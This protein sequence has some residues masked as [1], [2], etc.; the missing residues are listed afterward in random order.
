MFLLKFSWKNLTRHKRRTVITAISLAVGLM[1]FI[2]MD[3]ML[4][5]A[6][7]I[8]NRN[9][10][11]AETGHGKILTNLAFEDM[12]FSPLSN[13]I[14][15]PDSIIKLV[16][17]NGAKASKRVVINGEIIYSNEYFPKEGSTQVL[18]TAVDLDSDNNVF[19]VM[20]EKNLVDGRFMENGSD[21]VV[22]G[23]WLAED[24]GAKVG[25]VFTLSLRTA[26]EGD[27]PGF[28]Q[29]ID[30]EIVGIVNVE[31]PNVNRRVVYFPLDMA[32]FYLDLN[33]SVTEVAV[34]LPLNETID[35]FNKKIEST[36]PE[37]YGFF[38]WREIG[39][40]YLALTEAKSGG[41]SI[42]MMLV[43]FIA[44]VGITN[45]IL[46]TINER[47]RELGMMRALGMSDKSIKLAFMI[48]AAGIGLIGAISGV[49]LGCLANIPMVNIGIDFSS[50]MRHT[51]IGY[52]IS[53]VMYGV[54]NFSAIFKAFIGGIII[55]VIVA[56]FPTRSATKKSI[57]DCIHGR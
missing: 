7:E 5:G 47:Q 6:F 3:S 56:Y 55:P 36:L 23:S 46:M 14:E 50:Y 1:M 42:M 30:V 20:H 54:W 41:S 24:I 13:R 37:G 27:D 40:D 12:K 34:K 44:I 18:F 28:Y 15:N 45:T 22:I 11:D 57:P 48:E 51:D 25:S 26:S 2:L 53:N 31:S 16:E 21:E 35:S 29:T 38:T 39:A 10:M 9:L 19:N 8:S 49:I 32:D 17:S 43:I 4:V 33:G 52:R